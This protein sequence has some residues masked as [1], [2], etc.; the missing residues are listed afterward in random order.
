MSST[1]AQANAWSSDGALSSDG[2][3]V[4]FSSA[5][6]NLVANDSNGHSDVFVHDRATGTTSRVSVASDGSQG[7]NVS[8]WVQLSG[9]ARLVVFQSTA[10]NLVPNDHNGADDVFVH[11]RQTGQTTRVSV[12]SAGAE[13]DFGGGSFGHT[14]LDISADGRFVAFQSVSTNLV[15]NDTNAVD[16][17]F[18][19]DLQLGVTTRVSVSSA[20]VAGN[21]Q[22]RYPSISADGRWIAFDSVAANFVNGDTNGTFDVFVHDRLTGQTVLASASE[23][24]VI[25]NGTS[26][27]PELSADGSYVAFNSW[28]SN[29]VPNDANGWYD[30][31][32]RELTTGRIKLVSLSSFGGQGDGGSSVGGMSADGRYVAFTSVASNLVPGDT[33]GKQDNF[34][35]DMQLRTTVRVSV[36]ANGGQGSDISFAPA[37]SDDG[38]VF[39]SDSLAA[40]VPNDSNASADVFVRELAGCEPTVAS[41]CTAGTSSQGCTPTLSATGTPEAGASSGF[42]VSATGVDGQRN[43]LCFYGVS[44]PIAAPFANGVLC[45]KPPLQRMSVQNSGGT[46]GAC[47]GQIAFDWNQYVASHPIAVGAPFVGGETVWIQAWIRDPQTPFETALSDALWFQVCP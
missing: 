30:A 34:L 35:R 5:A 7:N 11:D 25:G 42:T 13:G 46:A 43:G 16:D 41:Y 39:A 4:A 33:N 47:D 9:D 26:Y 37:I 29:L 36:T 15:V 23:L 24:G 1:G 18:V 27:Y 10:T 44:G 20:G 38:R 6:S 32:R 19:R 28:A 40:L 14:P 2:R 3:V 17:I 31:F 8:S 12:D 45:V 21:D 22:S